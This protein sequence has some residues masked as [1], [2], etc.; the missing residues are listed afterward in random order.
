MATFKNLVPVPRAEG[1]GG[2]W[3]PAGWGSGG[4]GISRLSQGTGFQGSDSIEIE[5]TSAPTGGGGGIRV[6]ASLDSSDPLVVIEG[7]SAITASVYFESNAPETG[8]L[9]RVLFYNAD[10]GVIF[11]LPQSEVYSVDANTRIRLSLTA[12]TV[13]ENAHYM[14]VNARSNNLAGT[15]VGRKWKA[16][17]FLVQEGSS[18]N[19]YFDGS[20]L[21]TSE[22]I[23]EWSGIYNSSI[24]TM[25]N[26]VPVASPTGNIGLHACFK[27]EKDSLVLG[28]R[29]L[30][31]TLH[32]AVL[33]DGITEVDRKT[34]DRDLITG[35]GNAS[36]TGLTPGTT[37]NAKYLVDGIE[38][39]DVGLDSIQTLPTGASS[40]KVLAGSCQSTGSNHPIFDRM[41]EENALFLSHMGDLDYEDAT[42]LPVWAAAIDSSLE[43][44]RMQNMLKSLPMEYT[45]DNHDRLI[46]D[47]GGSGGGLNMGATDPESA[48]NYRDLAGSG[49]WASDVGMGRS[50]Q[51]GRVLFIQTDGW[52]ERDDPDFDTGTLTFLGAQQKA[53]FSA[54]VDAAGDN[55]S[56]QLIVWFSQWTNQNNGNGRWNSFP[57]E[58]AELEQVVY[59]SAKPF[60]MIGGDSHQCQ[61]DS[62]TRTASHR[63]QGTPS[64]NMSGFNKSG[65]EPGDEAP[66]WDITNAALRP[67][68]T[69]E[70]DVGGYS[71]FTVDDDG[72]TLSVHW[73]AV[74]VI[75]DGST[76]VMAEFS[77]SYSPNAE[78]PP[79]VAAGLFLGSSVA[80]VYVGNSAVHS[81]YLGNEV[82]WGG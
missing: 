10:G 32:T 24:S 79:A 26:D 22:E 44:P 65:S 57:E 5:F 62:G 8:V 11:P 19:D 60:I 68:T 59:R 70:S 34:V 39:T 69:P 42:T 28:H 78:V 27:F 54:Q 30:L 17:A 53:W 82:I 23:Y 76:D 15:T 56:I 2:S 31:G 50:W 58:S 40:F 64:L 49:P 43:A 16:S 4:E 47:L 52:T 1:P 80:S 72:V 21:N 55:S 12:T 41:D 35:W 73:E 29:R 67:P 61:A 66:G 63:F 6:G 25:S 33:Y 37:Y 20:T 46:K 14:Q 38:Q 45:W 18:L 74:R 71:R 75:L 48:A 81:V 3:G 77:R 13:P 7:L 9:L 51:A 36:F